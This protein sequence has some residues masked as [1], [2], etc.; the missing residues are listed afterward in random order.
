MSKAILR[1]VGEILK[2]KL[3][4]QG[5][6]IVSAEDQ[7]KLAREI[8]ERADGQA[9]KVADLVAEAVGSLAVVAS[10]QTLQSRKLVDLE[11]EQRLRDDDTRATLADIA[12]TVAADL[13]EQ[14]RTI[15][16]TAQEALLGRV[17]ELRASVEAEIEQRW[18][19]ALPGLQ[20]PPGPDGRMMA[21]KNWI[22]DFVY[23]TGDLVRRRGGLWQCEQD[24]DREPAAH[25]YYW[26][27]VADGL[28]SLQVMPGDAERWRVRA[29]STG[30]EV[31]E[32]DLPL[33]LPVYL[34]EPWQKTSAY[35][36]NE[37]VIHNRSR[38]LARCDNP[39]GRPGD[40]TDWILL[41]MAGKQGRAG[42]PGLDGAPGLPGP[43]VE[44]V[45]KALY[46]FEEGDESPPLRRWRGYW[47]PEAS[48]S[49]GDL[50][51]TTAALYVALTGN[52]EIQ[53]SD[54]NEDWAY[55][56]PIYSGAAAGGGGG[57][58]DHRHHGADVDVT[59]PFAPGSETV[60]ERMDDP[61]TPKQLP[62]VPLTCGALRSMEIGRTYNFPTVEEETSPG[63]G[64]TMPVAKTSIIGLV[65]TRHR[66][67]NACILRTGQHTWS[68]I[69]EEFTGTTVQPT[70]VW[71]L[72]LD[73][74]WPDHTG[75]GS[76]GATSFTSV[77]TTILEEIGDA[78]LLGA[79]TLVSKVQAQEK[80]EIALSTRIATLEGGAAHQHVDV[81]Q[82]FHLWIN[83]QGV[84][85]L[86]VND[87]PTDVDHIGKDL[88]DGQEHKVVLRWDEA[89]PYS[90][91]LPFD[92]AHFEEPPGSGTYVDWT[93][94]NAR[95]P[96]IWV[97]KENAFKR[98]VDPVTKSVFAWAAVHSLVDA[99]S[100]LTV[101]WN[102]AE[103][104]LEVFKIE[105]PTVHV[106]TTPDHAPLQVGG[107]VDAKSLPLVSLNAT[108]ITAVK[109]NSFFL[110]DSQK[111]KWKDN[112]GDSHEISMSPHSH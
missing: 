59:L 102:A 91:G 82:D 4:E 53:P 65:Q 25:S 66:Y 110:D 11:I 45:L 29:E 31:I 14:A 73:P 92:P 94:P 58:A 62:D 9:E 109:N 17:A 37:S 10:N 55:L 67:V 70:I 7:A 112:S 40:S 43:S 47:Q 107:G 60:Q 39:A 52:R 64:T 77:T 49:P 56:I 76:M 46:R 20:G 48:Y 33:P 1:A 79:E 30:G 111:L 74:L 68:A 15:E 104:S 75:V 95:A 90:A 19:A 78:T 84:G 57:S 97:N 8:A 34:E 88:F 3:E 38:W 108:Q 96:A 42:K 83:N 44:T 13:S 41:A 81:V 32:S 16:E 61:Y 98:L 85:Y 87:R 93:A 106:V 54:Y 18:T 2:A 22:P 105:A 69:A 80:A 35:R 27:L 24:T 72:D 12:R 28:H 51:K 21:V 50:V 6:L 101:K 71:S 89:L 63:S 100:V 99:G 26:R 86:I 36:L 5:A 103:D 23:A